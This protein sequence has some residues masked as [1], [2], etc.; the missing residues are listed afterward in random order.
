MQSMRLELLASRGR[1]VLSLVAACAGAL[2]ILALG[3]PD[4]RAH[5][6][7]TGFGD[8]AVFASPKASVRATW[9]DRAVNEN[10]K[11]VDIGVSWAD[12]AG[13]R[14][15]IDPANPADPEYH[16]G[17]L[18]GAVRDAR[19]RGLN[20]LLSVARAPDWAEGRHRPSTRRAAPGTWKPSAKDLG[21]FAQAIAKRYSGH[22]LDLPRVRY[23]QAWTE[24][25]LDS[26][27]TP[28]WSHKKPKSPKIYRPMLN[29]FYKGV[30]KAQAGAK[31]VTAGTAPYGDTPGGPRMRP[32]TFLRNLFCLK[33]NLER[34]CDK[35][36]HLD[37]LAHNPITTSGG[38]HK[39]A[40]NR[41]D[42]AI[43]DFHRVRKV[44]HAA[45]RRHQVRPRGRHQLWATEFWWNTDPPNR[46]GV[47]PA[48]QARWIEEAFYLLWKQGARVAV[49]FQIRDGAYNP[50]DPFGSPNTGVFFRDGKPKPSARGFRF[51]FVTHRRSHKKIVIWGKAPSTGKLRVQVRRHKQWHTKKRFH[52]R[53]GS[54][55]KR[56]LHLRGS[57]SLR[58]ELGDEHSLEW[59]QKKKH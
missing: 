15:P 54:V 9:L 48:K 10:A 21:R 55:F 56:T 41:N 1:A 50:K 47:S 46:K 57:A 32:L 8:G 43:P 42:I 53:N 30:K 16:F 22:F 44:L 36:P 59:R 17:S 33:H 12:V 31:V 51:P 5:G 39:K 45:E 49:N 13:S 38:P 58:A 29:A 24:P 23:F 11:I 26:H 25:N 7:I 4:A 34:K 18:D 37:V 6:L 20:V 14:P 52:V 28:Q 40:I 35:K 19:A 2:M 3:P 27:L